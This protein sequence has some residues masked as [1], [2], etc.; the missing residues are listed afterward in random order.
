MVFLSGAELCSSFI[1]DE[2]GEVLEDAGR[3]EARVILHTFDLNI[4]EELCLSWDP[5]RDR[6]P[7][8]YGEIGRQNDLFLY[9]NPLF[10]QL[11]ADQVQGL[12]RRR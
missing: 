5:F 10:L 12:F 2:T 11:F 3:T 1:T 7:E 8:L 4:M 9:Q 6:L